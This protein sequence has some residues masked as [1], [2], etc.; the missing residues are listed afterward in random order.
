MS[1]PS[2]E[3]II[4]KQN[5][6][7]LLTFNYSP[8]AYAVRLIKTNSSLAVICLVAFIAGLVNK[9]VILPGILILSIFGSL[10]EASTALIKLEA[11][12]EYIYLTYFQ[13][14]SK[15]QLM[16]KWNDIKIITNY[17]HI[18][19]ADLLNKKQDQPILR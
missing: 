8:E 3:T 19:F 5:A 16:L 1:N 2:N 9:L 6:T 18:S 11:W 10:K 4:R 13:G 7:P 12:D 17:H 15:K 14:Y